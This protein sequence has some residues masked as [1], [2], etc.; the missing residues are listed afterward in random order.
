[1]LVGFYLEKMVKDFCIFHFLSIQNLKSKF[2]SYSDIVP[3]NILLGCNQEQIR[4]ELRVSRL[5]LNMN[6]HYGLISSLC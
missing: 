2:S 5:L 1:M 6:F 3:S 4:T